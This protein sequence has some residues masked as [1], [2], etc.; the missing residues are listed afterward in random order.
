MKVGLD[1]NDDIARLEAVRA[2]VPSGTVLFCDA[3]GSWG[4]AETRRFLQATRSLDYTLEQPCASYEEN[5]AIRPAC[6]RAL[7]LDE[8]ID[9]TDALLRAIG[10]G[11]VDGITIKLARVG[12]LTKAKLLRDIA[13]ARNLKI[14]IEDTGGAQIDTAAYCG[15]LLSTPQLLRQHTVDFHNWVT[16]AN[17][18]ADFVI[19]DGAMSPPRR[20]GLGVDV[21]PTI[22]G[23]P[24]FRC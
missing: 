4:T 20:P 1:V 6:D 5:L 17:G 11:L 22:F 7:V 12:G 8:T 18:K 19:A 2:A 24:L 21:D 16:V 10:D 15:L 3:N 23:E 13:I 14:T 9:G